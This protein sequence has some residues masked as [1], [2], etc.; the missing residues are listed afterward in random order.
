MHIVIFAL[1]TLVLGLWVL[2]ALVTVFTPLRYREILQ[3]LRTPLITAFATGSV[4]IV[5]PL[6]IEQCRQLI[7]EA[8]T[9]D[10]E[11][12]EAADASVKVMAA[13]FF[14]F[15]GT[16]GLISSMSLVLFAG[17]FVGSTISASDYSLLIPAGIA[18]QFGGALLAVPF[19]LDL[20]RLPNDMFQ[21]FVSVDVVTARFAT[22]LSVMHLA[23]IALIGTF[24]LT[25]RVRFNWKKLA[26]FTVVSVGLLVTVIVGVRTFYSYVVVVPFTK[27]DALRGFTLLGEPQPIKAIDAPASPDEFTGTGPA[28]FQTIVERGLMRVCYQPNEFPSSFYNTATPPEL[29]GFDIEMAHRLVR[30][31]GLAIAFL[32]TADESEAE[33]YLYAGA[34]DIYMR[35]LPIS[36]GRTLMFGLTVTV[37]RTAVG[38]IVKDYRRD[39]FRSWEHLRE[40]GDSL[41]IGVDGSS[42]SLSLARDLLPEAELHPIRDMTEQERILEAGAENLDA[43]ADMAEQGAAWALLFPSFSAVIP[44]PTV[45]VPVAYAVARNSRDVLEVLNAWLVA[46]QAKGTIDQLYEHWM[47]GGAL[48]RQRPPRWSVIRD[49]LGWV[50]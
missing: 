43:V 28:G 41:H 24:A 40:L 29:V 2:P 15:P 35:K 17:W 4:L 10:E 49:V 46:E 8:T 50:D 9:F 12:Q 13:T 20:M 44:Q 34:C 26:S 37:F 31:S 1:S 33:K 14:P 30:R 27:A 32:P 39:E 6:L 7:T 18:S 3:G 48:K 36:G 47:L 22:L 25:T 42:E 38:L 5:L 16:G 23:T 11:K 45:F 21:V 19:L